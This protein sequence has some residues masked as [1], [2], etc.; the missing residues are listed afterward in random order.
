MAA[1]RDQHYNFDALERKL[2]ATL[3]AVEARVDSL[4]GTVNSLS[5]TVTASN[6]V[7]Y[8]E[9]VNLLNNSSYEWSKAAY[10][11]LLTNP[12]TVTPATAGDDNRQ[13]FNWFR[14][15]KT[16]TAL[17]Q[18]GARAL[19]AVGESTFATNE[20]TN[21]DIPRWDRTNGHAQIGGVTEQY[22]LTYKLPNAIV[23]P[24]LVIRLQFEAMLRTADAMPAGLQFYANFFDT[25]PG[26]MKIIEGGTFN[27]TGAIFGAD[28]NTSVSYLVIAQTD[29][30][31]T[32]VSNTLVFNTAPAVFTQNN[33]PRISFRGAPG[34]IIFDIYRLRGGV[35][36]YQYRIQNSIEGTYYDVGADPIRVVPN[37]PASTATAPQASART[38]TFTPGAVGTG[39][40]I[41]HSL[42][43]AVP[44]TYNTTLTAPG[45]Q[46]LR[47]G[48]TAPTSVARQIVIRRVGL[49]LGDGNWSRS[50]EDS[51]D[52]AH[53]PVS[54]SPLASSSGGSGGGV[55]N[56]PP[57]GSGNCVTLD[58]LCD[59][60][61][62]RGE[63]YRL[64]LR[65]IAAKCRT[66][67][68]YCNTNS[69]IF[70]KIL[71]VRIAYASRLFRIET[72][73]GFAPRCTFD[74]PFITSRFDLHGTP[75]SR[76]KVGSRL[77]Y[78]GNPVEIIGITEEFGDF[79]VG[80]P[81]LEGSHICRL[82]GYDS[83]NV[84]QQF[85]NDVFV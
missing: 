72:T 33:H 66:E 14:Q 36:T 27:I 62:E 61:D 25:T 37:F 29:S 57:N 82:G 7:S 68:L 44:T 43:I 71:E 22:D 55:G 83:H 32:A 11:T 77:Q 70:G 4:N 3:A 48:L 53:S 28:G 60:A 20:E 38:R 49:S 21:L 67:T 34:F 54:I 56:P 50:A 84:K 35:Y 52:G 75:A 9:I 47:F 42:T 40:F 58:T 24:G 30:G 65:E 12:P 80:I 64:S 51:R 79:E 85:F 74:H 45:N 41:R 13:A 10:T 18:T 8:A 76:L 16:V 23:F 59:V 19:K 5:H 78:L 15:L 17:D 73:A 26:Q 46:W 69:A 1:P 2:N 6:P 31:E 39:G 81:I 63:Y